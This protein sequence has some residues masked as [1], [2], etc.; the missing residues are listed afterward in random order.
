MEES[1]A[2]GGGVRESSWTEAVAVG[3]KTFVE[4]VKERLGIRVRGRKIQEEQGKYQ[5]RGP[6]S[7]YSNGFAYEKALLMPENAYIWD[8]YLK[9]S[10]R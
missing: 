1:L 6:S 5:L 7:P 10:E 9:I 2:N 8:I 3:S 4:K